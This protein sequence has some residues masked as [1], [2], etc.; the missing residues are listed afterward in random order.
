MASL[1]F[2]HAPMNSSKSAQLL[3]TAHNYEERNHRV[4]IVKPGVDSRD[5]LYVQSRALDTKRKVDLVI[6]P[7]DHWFVFKEVEE[8]D[9]AA[10]LV[11]EAQF[12]TDFQVDEL[13]EIVDDLG[14]P[15]L[16]YGLRTD[17]F[18]NLFTGSKRLF[19]VADKFQELKTICPCCGKKAVINMRLS[20]DNEPIFDGEQVSPG[21]HYVAVCRKYFKELKL[22]TERGVKIKLDL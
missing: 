15:V 7:D 12:L 20:E 14:I 13:A 3:M 2:I 17:S 19:E 22:Q 16:A 21:N 10:V 4:L 18:S 1:Y 8:T 6:G 9:Y 5:G 11:D